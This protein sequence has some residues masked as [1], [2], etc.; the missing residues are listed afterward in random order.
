MGDGNG[1]G[2]LVGRG[3]HSK[4][5]PASALAQASLRS[6]RF[7]VSPAA[8]PS[9]GCAAFGT[10]TAGAMSLYIP[11][12]TYMT[13]HGD[14]YVYWPTAWSGGKFISR[15]E[16]DEL[17]LRY[18]AMW[19]RLWLAALVLFALIFAIG[20]AMTALRLPPMLSTVAVSV[21]TIAWIGWWIQPSLAPW[22]LVRHREAILPPRGYAETRRAGRRRL[23]WPL[24]GSALA[25]L[26]MVFVRFL[27]AKPH[28]M[29]RTAMLAGYGLL[30]LLV[31]SIAVEKLLDRRG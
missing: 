31:L 28:G 9:L 6:G 15:A 18:R 23:S 16:F 1:V 22:R 19:Q 4:R 14:G 2:A 20:V 10:D 24:L 12:E 13:P 25:L 3:K 5:A 27:I 29:A 30:F 17:D 7:S 21:V 8:P 26:A 11:L